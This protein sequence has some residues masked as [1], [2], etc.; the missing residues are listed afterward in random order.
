[1]RE[2]FISTD[3]FTYLATK[4]TQW[5]NIFGSFPFER[6]IEQFVFKNELQALQVS[7]LNSGQKMNVQ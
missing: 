5:G 3:E 6:V 7:R 2:F 4:V 1:M